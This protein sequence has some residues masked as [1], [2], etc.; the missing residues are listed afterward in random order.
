MLRDGSCCGSFF[1]TTRVGLQRKIC[2]HSDTQQYLVL[3]PGAVR[4]VAA[5][6]G[7][8]ETREGAGDVAALK[9][10]WLWLPIQGPSSRRITSVKEHILVFACRLRGPSLPAGASG[11]SGSLTFQLTRTTA[12]GKVFIKVIR[13][14]FYGEGMP[15]SLFLEIEL[16]RAVTHLLIRKHEQPPAHVCMLP[17][18]TCGFPLNFP[19]FLV[20]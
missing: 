16:G 1:L 2:G 17:R 4:G 14:M 3:S 7:Q 18:C 20:D 6:L 13:F 12:M 5:L 10:L 11:A 19:L 15:C 8:G 9:V